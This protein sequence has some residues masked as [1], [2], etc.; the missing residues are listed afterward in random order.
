[1][2]AQGYVYDI[3]GGCAY[4]CQECRDEY[5]ADVECGQTMGDDLVDLYGPT[6]LPGDASCESCGRFLRDIK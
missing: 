5:M 4:S 2:S 3:G 1:M 6:S